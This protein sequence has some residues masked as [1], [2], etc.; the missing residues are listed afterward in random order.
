MKKKDEKIETTTK[1]SLGARIKQIRVSN[2][3]SQA[4]FANEMEITQGHMSQ[5]E[6]DIVSPSID[7]LSKIHQH[8]PDVNF[9]W[10]ISNDGDQAK[11]GNQADA[12][13]QVKHV[14]DELLKK[15]L[16]LEEE[17]KRLRKHE[18]LLMQLLSNKKD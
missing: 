14:N 13:H 17:I 7:V 6:N 18:D 11:N 2:H 3:K 16:Q 1:T 4:E 9:N 10:I 8:Y 15:N 12:M 5:L